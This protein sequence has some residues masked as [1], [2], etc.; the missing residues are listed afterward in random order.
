MEETQLSFLEKQQES[1]L[2]RGLPLC[3]K[4]GME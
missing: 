4:W 1:Y 2:K 3:K